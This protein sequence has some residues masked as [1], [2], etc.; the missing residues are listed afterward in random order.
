VSRVDV[1]VPCYNYG[2]FLRQCVESVLTQADVGV[3]VLILDDSSTDNSQEIGRQLAGEDSRVEYR[4]HAANRGHIATYNEGIEWASG[5]YTVLLSADDALT[6]GSL[7]RAA[8]L[9][10]AHPDV[11]LVHGQSIRTA[12]PS[13]EVCPPADDCETSVV[14]GLDFFRSL[15][16]TGQN[17]VETPTAVVRTSVHKRIGGYRA[18]LP[19]AGDM[20][21]WLR[22]SLHG[23]VGYVHGVQAYYRLHG[24]NMSVGFRQ[25]RDFRQRKEV[26]RIL[27][28]EYSNRIPQTEELRHTATVALAQDAFWDAASAF[29]RGD[30]G[31]IDEYLAFAADTYPPIQS[32]WAWRRLQ[33]KRA[34]GTR[35]WKLLRRP[36]RGLRASLAVKW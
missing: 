1:F 18:E 14:R 12:D 13:H 3:R 22:L 6:P 15:C 8:R 26:F 24:K 5:E 11:A 21:L 32:S 27:F 31:A 10:D 29:D 9:M 25:V 7:R 20:E 23:D 4:R 35:L 33:V 28:Q 19:H 16:E 30:M 34:M 2:R 17:V 36:V